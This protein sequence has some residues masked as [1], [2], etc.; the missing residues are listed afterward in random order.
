MPSLA[1]VSWTHT[2]LALHTY[3]VS[4]VQQQPRSVTLFSIENAPAPMTSHTT[5]LLLTCVTHVPSAAQRATAASFSTYAPLVSPTL[6]MASEAA[7]A[8]LPGAPGEEYLWSKGTIKHGWCCGLVCAHS[9]L[10]ETLGRGV[11]WSGCVGLAAWASVYK[12]V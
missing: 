5:L 6:T 11:Q 1:E 2:L 8:T 10:R 7:H 9:F 3:T 4:C 12:C